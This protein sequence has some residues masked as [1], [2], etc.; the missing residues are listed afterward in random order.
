MFPIFAIVPIVPLTAP[1]APSASA[2]VFGSSPSNSSPLAS[3]LLIEAENS[4]ISAIATLEDFYQRFSDESLVVNMWLQLQACAESDQALEKVQ[5]LMEHEA[6]DF[7][8]PNKH[9][10]LL[11]GFCT[12]NPQAFHA[13]DGSGYEFLADQIIALNE[14][15]PQLASRLITPLTHWGKLDTEHACLMKS[16]LK[17]I[18]EEDNL[19]K[20]VFEVVIKSLADKA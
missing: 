7:R 19:S 13:L 1:N 8:N 3:K 2:A 14:Q 6:F 15:N 12:Q 11:G 18:S 20:D 16:A 17:R 4:S 9:R 5:L 10:A